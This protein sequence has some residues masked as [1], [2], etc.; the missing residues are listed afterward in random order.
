MCQHVS[1]YFIWFIKWSYKPINFY[2][3]ASRWK[4][5]WKD[6]FQWTNDGLYIHEK[7]NRLLFKRNL[8]VNQSNKN[9]HRNQKKSK[10]SILSVLLCTVIFRS[11]EMQTL[12]FKCI[13]YECIQMNRKKRFNETLC[14][15]FSKTFTRDFI[16]TFKKL[17]QVI[18]SSL[19]LLFIREPY[20]SFESLNRLILIA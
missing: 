12:I 2:L 6:A 16:F 4:T 5:I 7:F 14:T 17:T 13:T 8:D 15:K 3:D 19:W 10:E 9:C 1:L 20:K 11:C 18:I